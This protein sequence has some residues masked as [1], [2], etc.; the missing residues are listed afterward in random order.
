MRWRPSE[1]RCL[2]RWAR[3]A[4]WVCW[5]CAALSPGPPLAA[6]SAMPS[7][8][9]FLYCAPPQAPIFTPC[10]SSIADGRPLARKGR[11]PARASQPLP[12]AC[13]HRL[14][15]SEPSGLL[16]LLVCSFEVTVC[17][18]MD[19]AEKCCSGIMLR[20]ESCS[21]RLS[22]LAPR[23]ALDRSASGRKPRRRYGGDDESDAEQ[24]LL[25]SEEGTPH[26]DLMGR[27]REQLQGARGGRGGAGRGG[28]GRAGEAGAGSSC[29][30]R[31]VGLAGRGG[32][33]ESRLQAG[34]ALCFAWPASVVA[35]RIAHEDRN[36]KSSK[37]ADRR[38]GGRRQRPSSA[39]VAPSLRG[40][41]GLGA[42]RLQRFRVSACASQPGFGSAE[43][44]SPPPYAYDAGLSRWMK[45]HAEYYSISGGERGGP[46]FFDWCAVLRRAALW[47]AAACCAMLWRA[48][49]RCAVTC[50][51]AL[52]CASSGICW[53]GTSLAALTAPIALR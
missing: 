49:L 51:G 25:G 53:E 11:G 4:C 18:S 22:L 7:C 15:P 37:I 23:S 1:R 48:A 31:W 6:S 28:A 46:T 45:R 42:S 47:R 17:F 40:C 26:L 3:C 36:F 9:F 20:N 41:P 8:L 30:V 2:L 5:A 16:L 14:V 52:R 44:C 29:R 50:C 35:P 38:K 19:H 12:A 39:D 27:T 33:G 13:G 34:L 32:A 43:S 10:A 21:H 24:P